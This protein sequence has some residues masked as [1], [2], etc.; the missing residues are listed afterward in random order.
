[1]YGETTGHG[2]RPFRGVG[3]L[4]VRI[5]AATALTCLFA[6]QSPQDHPTPTIITSDS[7]GYM[8]VPAGRPAL[9]QRLTPST[10]WACTT[11]DYPDFTPLS[12]AASVS[13]PATSVLTPT[14]SPSNWIV[15]AASPSS[16]FL[17]WIFTALFLAD[18]TGLLRDG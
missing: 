5:L 6:D 11:A 18:I 13:T 9:E 7:V 17:R 2:Y 3:W 15:Q 10:S 12:Y 1:M 8:A 16:S 14:W 4:V